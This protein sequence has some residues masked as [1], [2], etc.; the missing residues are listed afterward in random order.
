MN[1]L[2]LFEFSAVK[3][4]KALLFLRLVINIIQY[5]VY[6]SVNKLICYWKLYF[7]IVVLKF[8]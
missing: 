8:F 3:A 5:L 4:E 6:I 1:F 2:N 7:L